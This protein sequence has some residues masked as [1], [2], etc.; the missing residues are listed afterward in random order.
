MIYA[1]GCECRCVYVQ[2]Y[3]CMHICRT[4]TDRYYQLWHNPSM[5]SGVVMSRLVNSYAL[6]RYQRPN[7]I[8]CSA[9]SLRLVSPVGLGGSRASLWT[10]CFTYAYND[11]LHTTVI[12]IE[13]TTIPA[14][15]THSGA[16][17]FVCGGSLC[18]RSAVFV[19]LRIFHIC[20]TLCEP[21]GILGTRLQNLI[22]AWISNY[23]QY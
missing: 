4:S 16:K 8:L 9:L 20:H 10:D 5:P 1:Y 23:I 21:I 18:I 19:L 17:V 3:I 2:I 12:E 14:R 22:P 13:N 11:V 6:F 15:D 7:I